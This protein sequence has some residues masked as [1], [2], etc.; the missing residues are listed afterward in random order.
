P[1]GEK[2]GLGQ[3]S[4]IEHSRQRAVCRHHSS[5]TVH[6]SRVVGRRRIGGKKGAVENCGWS[7]RSADRAEPGLSRLEGFCSIFDARGVA[8]LLR[9]VEFALEFC[10][11]SLQLL[12]ESFTPRDAL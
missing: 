8:R 5:V 7:S 12:G 4:K 6:D 3:I 9:V 1:R 2:L 10:D 11:R